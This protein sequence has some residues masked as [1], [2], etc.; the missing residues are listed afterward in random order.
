[1][2]KTLHV[3]SYSWESA[4][5]A[6]E[7]LIRRRDHPALGA[8]LDRAL[9]RGDLVPVLGGIYR[10]ATT[11]LD[12]AT[13]VRAAVMY[14]PDAI[15][16]GAAAATLSWWPERG[17]TTVDVA[18]RGRRLDGDGIR[19]CQRRIPV[20]LTVDRSDVRF[21]DAALTVLDLIPSAGGNVIDEALRRGAVSLG[22]LEALFAG[23]TPRRGDVLR[24]M[25]LDDSRDEPWSEAE[26]QLQRYNRDL[27][28]PYVHHTNHEVTLPDGTKRYL[29]LALP[30]LLLAFEAD[31]WETHGT[32][33]AFVRDRA[34]DVQLARINWQR[35]RFDAVTIFDDEDGV[36]QAMREIVAA[37][38]SLFKGLW[39]AAPPRKGMARPRRH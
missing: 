1:M 10:H 4:L 34:S 21:T 14:D 19:W 7:G 31:G 17:A 8:S 9:G 25:L 11:E 29:D 15:V 38:E 3:K 26:R 35:I 37:R 16:V 13:R 18:S 22:E 12:L 30:D 36:K 33:P 23:M 6:G 24:R 28:L 27:D 32:Q 39:P 20:D 5:E 2:P